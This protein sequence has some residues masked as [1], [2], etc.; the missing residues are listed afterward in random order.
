[1]KDLCVIPFSNGQK[2]EMQTKMFTNASSGI[3]IPLFEARA[4]YDT[5]LSDLDRQELVT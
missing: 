1:M 4:P 2:F 5:Y 3:V